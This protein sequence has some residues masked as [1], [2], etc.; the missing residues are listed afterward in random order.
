[1]IGICIVAFT[2]QFVVGMGSLIGLSLIGY[3]ACRAI[4]YFHFKE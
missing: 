4:G 3:S 1:M 2:I